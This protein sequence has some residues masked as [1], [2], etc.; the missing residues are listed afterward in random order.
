[1]PTPTVDQVTKSR[2]KI[3]EAGGMHLS[4]VLHPEAADALRYL[5]GAGY[6]ASKARAIGRALIEAANN[7]KNKSGNK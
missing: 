7:L 2:K 3:I 6:E 4:G 5:M 1:M